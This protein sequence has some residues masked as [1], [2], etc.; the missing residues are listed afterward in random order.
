MQSQQLT[1]AAPWVPIIELQKGQTP[2]HYA[3]FH[4]QKAAIKYLLDHGADPDAETDVR[5]A[6]WLLVLVTCPNQC[7]PCLKQ[8]GMTPFNMAQ[9]HEE[10]VQQQ[11]E[12][13][14][15]AASISSRSSSEGSS[16]TPAAVPNRRRSV[17]DGE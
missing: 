3:V 16:G 7:P 10:K 5:T 17:E 14:K 12:G 2:L 6:G 8:F 15:E 11:E 13:G 4:G 1:E 9:I